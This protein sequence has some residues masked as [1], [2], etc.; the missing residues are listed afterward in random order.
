MRFALVR[1]LS[2]PRQRKRSRSNKQLTLVNPWGPSVWGHYLL[3]PPPPPCLI[4]MDISRKVR[5]GFTTA[6]PCLFPAPC[7]RAR[8]QSGACSNL[9]M[10]SHDNVWP[11]MFM[12]VDRPSARRDPFVVHVAHKIEAGV[13]YARHPQSR[14]RR[15]LGEVA[16]NGRL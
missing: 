14:S 16:T 3:P 13:S 4:R 10:S 6:L 8:P 11:V 1:L 7:D 9:K 12:M 15:L 2:S 5:S